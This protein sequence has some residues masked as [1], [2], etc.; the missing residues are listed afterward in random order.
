[1]YYY[2]RCCFDC[3]YKCSSAA[4]SYTMHW[5]YVL[6]DFH[7]PKRMNSS[8][9]KWKIYD[10]F[11][12]CVY[13]YVHRWCLLLLL[14][15]FY[16]YLPVYFS[17]VCNF[18]LSLSLSVQFICFS[19]RDVIHSNN[20]FSFVAISYKLCVVFHIFGYSVLLVLFELHFK[21]FNRNILSQPG[22]HLSH[23]IS[24][25]WFSMNLSIRIETSE[26]RRKNYS[27]NALWQIEYNLSIFW[28]TLNF[29]SSFQTAV[30]VFFSF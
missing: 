26:K 13:I 8:A 1:M 28:R 17:T 11:F 2:D 30:V 9:V 19:I 7:S 25:L 3:S 21:Y 5:Y 15:C 6:F 22:K 10:D 4:T 24:P 27:S 14:I 12:V 18:S 16:Y 29:S 20:S 23:Y